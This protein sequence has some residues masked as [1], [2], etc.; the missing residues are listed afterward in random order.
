MLSYGRM[1]RGFNLIYLCARQEG[2]REPGEPGARVSRNK[3]R[4]G[5]FKM[6]EPESRGR[7]QHLNTYSTIRA[8]P[9]G[10]ALY[11]TWR[12]GRVRMLALTLVSL[13][14][15]ASSPSIIVLM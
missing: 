6:Q 12:G 5:G 2:R 3:G 11:R 14:P 15:E 7:C 10:F 1:W 13:A 4:C 9:A 8:T